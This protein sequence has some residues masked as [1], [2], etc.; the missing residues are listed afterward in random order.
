[1]IAPDVST[2]AG[3]AG[4]I[5]VHVRG[6]G[7]DVVL[8]PSL[9]RGAQDFDHLATALAHA[10]YRSIA[11]E[12]RGIGASTAPL[13]EL[14]MFD[15]AADAAAAID[16]LDAAPATVVGHAFGNRV[17][18]ML[19]TEYPDLVESCVLL[20]CGGLVPPVA[21]HAAALGRVFATDVVGDEHLAA[22]TEAFFAP[23]NDASVWFDGW[24]ATVARSQGLATN[25]L[26]PA[27]WWQ[28]GSADVLVV[29]PADDVV[30]P[31]GNA[32]LI[33]EQ[34]GDR[35]TAVTID[36]AGH[37]LLPEQPDAVAAAVLDWLNRR[38][39]PGHQA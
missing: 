21:Q 35:S 12:P 32:A 19:A 39:S 17:T 28:A 38:R 10:G 23:G 25:A 24:H 20:A 3:P 9:G 18:R 26:D 14:T 22:V 1:M 13:D 37:A 16:A 8:I 31:P 5:E 15:L 7:P 30:A 2:I 6:D 36:N 11:P 33:V 27:H 4:P 29:Q 34:L